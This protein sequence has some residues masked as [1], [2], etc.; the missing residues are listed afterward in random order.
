MKKTI[1]S[2]A[3][4]AGM[5]LAFAVPAMAA[6]TASNYGTGFW[7]RNISKTNNV[8]T[9]FV[10]NNQTEFVVNKLDLHT[11]TGGSM[12][13]GNVL[14]PVNG[15][16]GN[17]TTNVS[18]GTDVN[19]S[20]TVVGSGCPCGTGSSTASNTY[21]GFGSTNVAKI[22]N[23]SS[24]VVTNNQNAV[25][26][27]DLKVSADTGHSAQIGNTVGTGSQVGGD[28]KTTVTVITNANNSQTFI[29]TPVQVSN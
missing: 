12:S 11:N 4:G 18:V 29:N 9:N 1:I 24:N 6:D 23:I 7:S 3:I 17:V 8:S 26:I 16:S 13:I 21:T 5:L 25:V 27:N 10:G 14:T 19:R 20:L 22:N 2:A 28:V 15:G